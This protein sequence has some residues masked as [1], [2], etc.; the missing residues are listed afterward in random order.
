MSAGSSDPARTAVATPDGKGYWVVLQDGAIYAEGDARY[1]GSWPSEAR[2][3]SKQPA[4]ALV[5]TVD[6]RGAWLVFANGT[7]EALGDAPVLGNLAG[8]KINAPVY[9]AAAS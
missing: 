9:A 2:P 4:Q 5:P 3:V 6:G 8:I 7:V 1:L